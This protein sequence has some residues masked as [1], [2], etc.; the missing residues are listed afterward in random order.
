MVKEIRA[1]D[2]WYGLIIVESAKALTANVHFMH[3]GIYLA[4]MA[5]I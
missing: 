3:F 2:M 1:T 5:I 4:L